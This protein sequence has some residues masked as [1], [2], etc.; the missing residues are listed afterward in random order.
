MRVASWRR[1]HL[2]ARRWVNLVSAFVEKCGEVGFDLLGSGGELVDQ[3]VGY[4]DVGVELRVAAAGV[5]VVKGGDEA[6]TRRM[7]DHG[8]WTACAR[9]DSTWRVCGTR[10]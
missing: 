4:D 7:S 10:A 8:W 3:F 1:I 5:P 9:R 6:A 2:A